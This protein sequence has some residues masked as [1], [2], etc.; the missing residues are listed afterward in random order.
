[1]LNNKKGR[2]VF[3]VIIILAVVIAAG[4]LVYFAIGGRSGRTLPTDVC[5]YDN[6]KYI[7]CGT[8]F[9]LVSEGVEYP[10]ITNEPF[11]FPQGENNLIG[12]IDKTKP[13]GEDTFLLF[14][15]EGE[16]TINEETSK[17][18]VGSFMAQN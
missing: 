10:L 8:A 12:L 14:L 17:R 16:H 3:I 18:A 7:T 1:M 9:V 13:E 2:T 11:Y 15:E 5:I 6:E 4:I